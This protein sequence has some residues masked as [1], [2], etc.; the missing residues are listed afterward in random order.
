M[1]RDI[2]NI[3][4]KLFI[5]ICIFIGVMLLLN[6]VIQIMDEKQG[7]YINIVLGVSIPLSSVMITYPLMALANMDKN[8][9]KL[10][11]QIKY[12]NDQ[13]ELLNDKI[14]DTKRIDK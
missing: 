4:C 14:E 13:I 9:E 6:G 2:V 11:E 8:V 1:N 5:G 3:L 10:N 7:W 12:L